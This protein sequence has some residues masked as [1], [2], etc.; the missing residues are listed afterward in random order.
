MKRNWASNSAAD[1][2]IEVID[3]S[4]AVPSEGTE[5][6]SLYNAKN[7]YVY[8]VFNTCIKG[9]QAMVIVRQFEVAMDGR[10]VYLG[11]LGF[12]ERKANL[13]LI[14]TKC[15]SELS[16][17]K[18]TKNY[19]GGA[20]KF[21]QTFQNTYLDLENATGK[22]ID[23]DEKIGTLNASLDDDRFTGVRTTIETMALQT[24]NMIN[25]AN[26][27]QSMITH[28]ENLWSPVRRNANQLQKSGNGSSGQQ[29]KA[30]NGGEDMKWTKDFTLHVPYKYFSKLPEAEKEKRIEARA[31]AKAASP[32]PH[33][34]NS[35]Q[36]SE[37]SAPE[38]N[39]AISST[40]RIVAAASTFRSAQSEGVTQMRAQVFDRSWQVK[41]SY[42]LAP[43]QMHQA[44]A[45]RSM[46]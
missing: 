4:Y 25:Y 5:S 42:P 24:G 13:S 18:L 35:L 34:V 19:Q 20:L 43:I 45:F 23:D 1:D 16:E 14:R 7:R 10:S 6:C 30:N 8:N 2:V 21:F 27:L 32:T 26:Y 12:Y 40:V 22:V 33:S 3:Q 29:K 31:A 36:V 39:G 38:S 15:M 44:D 37:G 41:L 17:L 46:P 11:M 9:G 28:A